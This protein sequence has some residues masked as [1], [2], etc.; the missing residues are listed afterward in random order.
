MRSFQSLPC[1]SDTRSWSVAGWAWSR[2]DVGLALVSAVKVEAF[3]LLISFT[4]TQLLKAELVGVI[5]NTVS[6]TPHAQPTVKFYD[7]GPSAWSLP[8][9]D[10]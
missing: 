3:G 8:A 2:Q 7:S 10:M 9:S 5:L 6:V 4:T 1:P